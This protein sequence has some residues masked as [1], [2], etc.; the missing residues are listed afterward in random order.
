M[1]NS[2]TTTDFLLME[3]SDMRDL[4]LFYAMI[5]SLIYL[6]TVMGNLVIAAVTTLDKSLHTPMYFFLRNLSI[7]DSCYISVTVPKSYMNSLLGTRSISK[8]GCGAQ[9]F[10]VLLFGFVEL[11]FLT[12]M[13][14][15]R[16]AAICRPLH[17][18]V[19]MSPHLCVH[20]TLATLLSG[21]IYAALHT[22]NTFRLPFCHSH[23]VQQLFCDIPSLLKLSCSDTF[24]NQI[25]NLLSTLVIGGGCFIYIIKSYIHIFSTVLRFP[26][27]ADRKKAF[28]TCVPHI[29][30]VSVFLSSGSYVYL[31]PS[32]MSAGLMDMVLSVFYSTVPPLFNP[33]IHSL[34][35]EQIKCAIRELMT[36]MFCSGDVLRIKE[37]FLFHSSQ[38]HAFGN[39]CR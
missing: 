13:A 37:A 16:F 19:I 36:R 39:K 31:R 4:Q 25:G 33:I 34:R 28:S 9:V 6:L 2:S 23:A 18:P 10:L 12:I 29:L 30:V 21:L 35:N 24:S 38:S 14:H 5:F 17:Y 8:A 26:V 22:L 27:G 7:L 20:S 15:D 3:I 32:A 11:L 1:S